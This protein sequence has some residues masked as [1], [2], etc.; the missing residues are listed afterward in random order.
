MD[1]SV[2]TAQRPNDRQCSPVTGSVVRRGG[3][4]SLDWLR[5]RCESSA[6]PRQHARTRDGDSARARSGTG[7][8]DPAIVDRELARFSF[9]R[10]RRFGDSVRVERFSA[11]TG[12]R[13]FAAS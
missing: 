12:A 7:A 4:G 8:I 3:I 2:V 11:A 10:N 1:G 5:E 6:R 13:Q 9:G